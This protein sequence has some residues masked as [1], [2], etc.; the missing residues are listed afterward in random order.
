MWW[1]F[2]W[3]NISFSEFLN[4]AIIYISNGKLD[5]NKISSDYD[6]VNNLLSLIRHRKFLIIFDGFERLLV[7]YNRFN[8]ID[9][10][11]D[12]QAIDIG[13]HCIDANAARFLLEISSLDRVFQTKIFITSRMIINDLED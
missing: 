12:D 10:D 13:R 7:D 2:Y 1:S 5:P 3:G 8:L 11:D 6:K 4:K 9:Q